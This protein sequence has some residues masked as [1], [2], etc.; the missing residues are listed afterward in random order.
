MDFNEKGQPEFIQIGPDFE[1]TKS[2]SNAGTSAHHE[3]DFGLRLVAKFWFNP[4]AFWKNDAFPRVKRVAL[5]PLVAGAPKGQ[6]HT[7]MT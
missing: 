4:K 2:V 5:Y 3:I 1:T 7:S 6:P